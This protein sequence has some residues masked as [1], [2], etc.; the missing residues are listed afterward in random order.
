MRV[1]E[2]SGIIFREFDNEVIDLRHLWYRT[3]QLDILNHH[4]VSLTGFFGQH[5]SCCA[6]YNH[7]YISYG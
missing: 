4:E 5:S 7:S 1:V 3:R 2:M 6:S